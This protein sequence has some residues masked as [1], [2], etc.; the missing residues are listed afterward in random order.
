MLIRQY[1]SSLRAPERADPI[2][3]QAKSQCVIT[4]KMRVH[5]EGYAEN[6]IQNWVHR[7]DC[8]GADERN[9]GRREEALK[10]PVVRSM[11]LGRRG[12]SGGVVNSALDVGYVGARAKKGEEQ[13]GVVS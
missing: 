12:E 5:D 2:G 11:G 13:R 7:G 9:Q 8:R 3:A 1:L 10:R 4:Y 6:S